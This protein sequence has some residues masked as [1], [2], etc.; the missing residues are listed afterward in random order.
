[1]QYDEWWAPS[2]RAHGKTKRQVFDIEVETSPYKPMEDQVAVIE[3]AFQSPEIAEASWPCFT[4][5]ITPHMSAS[6]EACPPAPRLH[7]ATLIVLWVLHCDWSVFCFV[8]LDQKIAGLVKRVYDASR[9]RDVYLAFSQSP[10]DFINA[11]IASQVST[12][13]TCTRIA[14]L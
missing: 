1:M 9:R 2:C 11:L 8:Q 7:C 3:R 12:M 13:S 4:S 10:V 5:Y 14:Q 6:R